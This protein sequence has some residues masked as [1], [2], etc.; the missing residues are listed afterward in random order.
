MGLAGLWLTTPKRLLIEMWFSAEDLL[1]VR[2]GHKEQKESQ[3]W[4]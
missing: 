2:R 3:S 1:T 4:Q